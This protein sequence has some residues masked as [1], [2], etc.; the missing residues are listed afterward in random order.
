MEIENQQA[1]MQFRIL[2]SNIDL[3]LLNLDDELFLSV[4]QKYRFVRDYFVFNIIEQA[5]HYNISLHRLKKIRRNFTKYIL[6]LPLPKGFVYINFPGKENVYIINEKGIVLLRSNFMILKTNLDKKNYVRVNTS[7][8]KNKHLIKY[9]RLHRLV[10]ETFIPNP[11]NLPQVNHIDG[12]KLNNNVSNL[13]WCTNEYNMQHAVEN[14][15]RPNGES[16][17]LSKLK[18]EDV[19]DILKSKF[20]TSS[21]AKKFNVNYST[22]KS[23]TNRFTWKHVIV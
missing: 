14:N 9:K 3:I 10:A 1:S 2:I 17:F 8:W 4:Q 12:N 15:L 21:L 18:E 23:I 19:K 6:S 5:E 11:L 16:C 20:S 7:Y 13:E 22:I